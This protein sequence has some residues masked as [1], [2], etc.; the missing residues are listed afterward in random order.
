[1][2]IRIEIELDT[3]DPD[4]MADL[5]EL[6]R[7]K[8]RSEFRHVAQD[9]AEQLVNLKQ[10]KVSAANKDTDRRSVEEEDNDEQ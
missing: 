9:I 6:T 4:D 2:K 5:D 1:L 7:L 10:L 3:S 8:L